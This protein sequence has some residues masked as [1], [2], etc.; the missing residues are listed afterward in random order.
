MMRLIWFALLMTAQGPQ[1]L[2][3]VDE[4]KFE[5]AEKCDAFGKLMAPRMAD[6]VRGKIDAPWALEIPIGFRCEPIGQDT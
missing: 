2:P 4:T 3:L 5:N 6:F 1:I